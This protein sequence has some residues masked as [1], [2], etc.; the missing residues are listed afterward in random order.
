MNIAGHVS[1]A[2]LLRYSHVVR[3]ETTPSRE[4]TAAS[5]RVPFARQ[6][7]SWAYTLLDL[8]LLRSGAKRYYGFG[9]NSSCYGPRLSGN[10]DLFSTWS[11]AAC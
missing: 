7:K 5:T 9:R 2:M 6:R 4:M 8:A 11:G 3:M 1:R 10:R